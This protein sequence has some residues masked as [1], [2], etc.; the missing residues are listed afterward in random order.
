V[1][2][3]VAAALGSCGGESRS[4]DHT[5][6]RFG[7]LLSATTCGAGPSSRPTPFLLRWKVAVDDTAG[8]AAIAYD[9]YR[10]S[11]SGAHDFGRPT[12]TAP[13][14]AT[15]FRTPPLAGDKTWYFVVRARDLAGN[16]D[17]NRVEREG[18]NL[19]E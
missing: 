18:Q 7:G 2:V 12:Y 9:I 1:A 15:S 16:A 3:A 19:C 11:T 8:R 6:P 4:T 14:G 13:A 5:P 10:S 17:A